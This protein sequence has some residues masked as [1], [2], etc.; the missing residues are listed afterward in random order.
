[1]HH[2]K[3]DAFRRTANARACAREGDSERKSDRIERTRATKRERARARE[4]ESE[5]GGFKESM[6]GMVGEVGVGDEGR[7]SSD[8]SRVH[9]ITRESVGSVLD[10]H[11]KPDGKSDVSYRMLYSSLSTKCEGVRQG[12]RFEE[13]SHPPPS[14]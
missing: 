5:R 13:A 8:V 7:F 9:S 3:R 4:R 12:C 11:W 1:M 10:A 14:V 6:V 2:A